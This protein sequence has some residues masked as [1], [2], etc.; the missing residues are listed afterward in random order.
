MI[1]WGKLTADTSQKLTQNITTLKSYMSLNEIHIYIC[2][3]RIPCMN[4]NFKL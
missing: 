1:W 3:T 2:C 4:S